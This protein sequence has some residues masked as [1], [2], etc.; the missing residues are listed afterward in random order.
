MNM[1]L[2]TKKILIE[3]GIYAVGLILLSALHVVCYN[4]MNSLDSQG[5]MFIIAFFAFH[6]V[7][8]LDLYIAMRIIIIMAQQVA[9][10][11]FV[12]INL[13]KQFW[14]WIKDR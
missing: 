1:T 11:S 10:H 2:K 13:I 7:L 9:C 6:L 8:L 5:G 4:W 3:W 14:A 12:P